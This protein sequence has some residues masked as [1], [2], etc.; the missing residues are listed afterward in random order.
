MTSETFVT[1]GISG[2]LDAGCDVSVIARRRPAEQL[3][4]AEQ[5]ALGRVVP[6]T[7]ID[8]ELEP[9]E[10]RP[11]A[12]VPLEPGRHDV[13]HAHFGSNARHY[14]FARAQAA[15]PL[16]TT[17]HGYDFSADPRA[18]GPGM[19]DALFRTVD[20]IT[21]NAEHA[22][23][24]LEALGCPPEKLHLARMPIEVSSFAFRERR[25]DGREP[26]RFVTVGR[27]VEKKGHELTLHALSA[28]RDRLPACRYDVVGDGPKAR[29][30]ERLV[31]VLG[32]EQVV[33]FHGAVDSTHVRALLERA[34]VFV[35]GSTT[36]ADG[37]VEGT[38]ISLMEAQACGLP[39]VSTRHGGIE[40]VV[41]DG[42]SG[43]LVEEGNG[44]ALAGALLRIVGAHEA[45][46]E[47][48]AAGRA[49]IEARYD[50]GVCAE[51]MLDA[52]RA[53]VHRY[54]QRR[55]RDPALG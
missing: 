24:A 35:L 4:H 14:L 5:R 10:C 3:V 41:R 27:L 1:T 6:T 31:H 53:A 19:Y 49:H 38:P 52:Y 13:L 39:V 17:F 28:A 37:D 40:E 26:V 50:V 51:L 30:L 11:R 7:Y 43:F 33:R 48:G 45:W 36:A 15:A 25:W 29:D 8:S 34:H 55:A 44:A 16:V 2:L 32:L 18:H 9:D 20:A 21:Y 42:R 23:T 47:L 12:S 54:A 46:P 22:R